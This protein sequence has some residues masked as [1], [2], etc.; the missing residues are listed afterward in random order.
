MIK[1]GL[2]FLM[3]VILLFSCAS[4][5]IKLE[6]EPLFKIQNA[7]FSKWHSGIKGGGSGFNIKVLTQDTEL[8]NKLVGLYFRNKYAD[9]KF[10]KPNVYSA[11]IQTEKPKE[12]NLDII[13]NSSVK[14]YKEDESNNFPFDIEPN[15][16][17]IVCLIKKK[18][19]Y[20]KILLEKVDIGFPR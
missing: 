13:N 1:N 14:E 19:K 6:K 15:E 2:S 3:V 5:K 20:F 4:N 9:F 11:F 12:T 7:Q 10:N 16:A 17:V 8:S 18:K